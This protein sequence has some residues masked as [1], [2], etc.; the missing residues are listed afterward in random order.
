M[1]N[2]IETRKLVWAYQKQKVLNGIDL[3]VPKGAIY[4]YLGR[5][6]A[7]KTSTI[8]LLMGLLP[9]KR[10][11]VYFEGKEFVANREQILQKVGSLIGD[12]AYYNLSA[13]ENLQVLDDIYHCGKR[14]IMEMLEITGLADDKD[15]K[16]PKFS[17]GMKQRL[18]IAMALLHDPDVIILDEPMNGLDPE[19]IYEI[20]ELLLKLKEV[21]KTIFF[22]S[23]ILD[24]MEKICTHV[25]ILE[26]GQLI[27]QGTLTA[28]LKDVPKQVT[29]LCESPET[30]CSLFTGQQF[31]A[32]VEQSNKVSVRLNQSQSFG[33][34]IRLLAKADTTVYNI[35]SNNSS[36]ENIYLNLTSNV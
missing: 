9:A 8:K 30:V 13:K 4:G 2:A 12:P 3:Q 1:T 34:F 18:G 11:S 28:L 20:R 7:G 17:T 26:R 5:N 27:Y 21:G 10:N 22:S 6:G 29:V 24:E 14:R 16:V 15:K 35:E 19:G 36:L 31:D 33:D 32:Y 25:G 23:H